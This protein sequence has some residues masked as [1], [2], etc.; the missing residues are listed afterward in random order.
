MV[1]LER[2]TPFRFLI[3]DR[4]SKF[5]RSF[6]AVSEARARDRQYR[7]R[8]RLGGLAHAHLRSMEYHAHHN[9]P[10]TRFFE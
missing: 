7:C 2:A 3:R 6:D 4:D 1:V 5:T 8:D 10:P 9:G